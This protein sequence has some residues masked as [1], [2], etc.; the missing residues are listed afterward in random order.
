[1]GYDRFVS[2]HALERAHTSA[3]NWVGRWQDPMPGVTADSPRPSRQQVMRAA[4]EALKA[5][6]VHD[7]EHCLLLWYDAT[8]PC[9]SFANAVASTMMWDKRMVGASFPTPMNHAGQTPQW[10]PGTRLAVIRQ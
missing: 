3:A 6:V 2:A 7:P 10:G 4:A 9:G 1:M 5:V 8:E